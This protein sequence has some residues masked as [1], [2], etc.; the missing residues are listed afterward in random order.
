[1]TTLQNLKLFD[2]FEQEINSIADNNINGIYDTF[3]TLQ[4][5]LNQKIFS[6]YYEFT[7]DEYS[8]LL[9]RLSYY[10]NNKDIIDIFDKILL[11]RDFIIYQTN[12]MSIEIFMILICY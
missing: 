10:I 9:Y 4:Y 7:D 12:I 8:R 1:M 3:E 5:I 2:Y 11:C 6:S